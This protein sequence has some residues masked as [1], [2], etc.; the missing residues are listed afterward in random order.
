MRY[1]HLDDVDKLLADPLVNLVI[2]RDLINKMGLVTWEMRDRVKIVATFRGR[3]K[4]EAYYD[5]EITGSEADLKFINSQISAWFG[6]SETDED[7]R[8]RTETI[9]SD[10]GD[11]TR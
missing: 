8:P 5:V 4:D 7:Y 3:G 1:E 10:E 9:L 2:A 11:L 6:E